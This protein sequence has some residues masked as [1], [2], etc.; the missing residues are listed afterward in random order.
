LNLLCADPDTAASFQ[1]PKVQAAMMDCSQNPNNI[2]KYQDDPEIM[3]VFIKLSS[4]F[5][6]MN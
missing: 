3:S 5:P 4:M 2:S 6:G 1:N